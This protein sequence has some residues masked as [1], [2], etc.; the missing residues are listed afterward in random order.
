MFEIIDF[1]TH[2]FLTDGQNIC[3]HKAVI[4]MTTASSKEYLQGLA[5]HKICGSVVST[6]CY[7]EPGDMWKK[8]QRNNASAYALQERY[9]DFYIPGIHVHPLFVKESCEEIEK[10]AK[11]G[12]RLIGELVP[13]L[14]GWKEY[15]DPAF[16]EILDV[17]E[18]YHM[19]VSFHSS[20]ED[21]MDNMVKSHPDLTF[22]AAHPGEY[23]AFMRHLERMKHSENYHLDL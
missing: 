4:P 1:H 21:K 14:D 22:V 23:S 7:T 15:D 6:D 9:G 18:V 13:Y 19:V 16:L 2:P 12:V 20:D 8:I 3:N 11:A 17:A 5:I 10:A